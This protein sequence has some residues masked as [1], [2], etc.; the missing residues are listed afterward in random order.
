VKPKVKGLSVVARWI[1][2]AAL[3]FFLPL[4]EAAAQVMYM[5]GN[6]TGVV[7]GTPV[8]FGLRIK[9]DMKTGEETAVVSNM[10]PDMGAILRQ[11]TAIVTVA[12]PTFGSTPQGGE[13]LFRLSGGNFVNSA[14]VYWPSTKDKLELIHN[15]T[16]TGGDTLRVS[17]TINGTVPVISGRD[18]V[19]FKDFTEIMYWRDQD[20][21]TCRNAQGPQ[22]VTTGVGFDGDFSQ[23]KFRSYLVGGE[24]FPVGEGKG[25]TTNYTGSRPSGP[26]LRSGRDITTTYDAARRTMNVHLYNVLTPVESAP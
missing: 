2:V 8:D 6:M 11:V 24:P 18:T 22:V 20:C 3:C 7:N 4:S 10:D 21:P 14:T 26:V 19:A 9:V 16:Y 12:G 1:P 23:A 13:N 17:A 5:V 15:V 25:S